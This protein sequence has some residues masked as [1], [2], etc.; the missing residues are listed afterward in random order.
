[1]AVPRSDIELADPSLKRLDKGSCAGCVPKEKERINR[2][3]IL[4][5]IY[6]SERVH[7][8]RQELAPFRR[9]GRL[10]E[11]LRACLSPLLYKSPHQK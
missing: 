10:P 8:S 9:D 7:L 6:S 1:M 5:R 4:Q 11:G 2:L 3:C